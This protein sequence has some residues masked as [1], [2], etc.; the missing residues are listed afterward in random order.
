MF[1]NEWRILVGVNGRGTD[2]KV[3]GGSQ[4]MPNQKRLDLELIGRRHL[5]VSVRGILLNACSLTLASPA[6]WLGHHQD[7]SLR[8]SL[9]KSWAN[10]IGMGPAGFKDQTMTEQD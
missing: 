7:N 10:V 4:K 9:S 3:V 2:V 1:K 5:P 8:A 6:C